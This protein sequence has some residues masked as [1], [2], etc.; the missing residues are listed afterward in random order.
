[1]LA[2]LIKLVR[3]GRVLSDGA[4]GPAAAYAPAT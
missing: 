1:V 4:P 3:E 2:H